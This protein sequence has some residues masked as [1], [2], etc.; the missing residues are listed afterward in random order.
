MKIAILGGNGFVGQAIALA[1]VER[2]DQVTSYSRHGAPKKMLAQGL[3]KV[4][5]QQAD[6]VADTDWVVQLEEF[7]WVVDCIGILFEKPSQNITYERMT[8]TPVRTFIQYYQQRAPRPAFAFVSAN[9]KGPLPQGYIQTKRQAEVE[10]AHS[11]LKQIVFYPGMM[12]GSYRPYSVLAALP[13]KFLATCP[14][15]RHWGKIFRPWH[16]LE[17]GREVAKVLHGGRSELTQQLK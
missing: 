15:L 5:W 12:Y 3:T 16:H 9:L 7:D 13:L 4:S 14:G 2:H 6:V 11:R 10:L 17:F 1:L 8:L